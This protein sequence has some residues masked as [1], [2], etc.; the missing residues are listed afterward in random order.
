MKIDN[1]KKQLAKNTLIL[2]IG[3]LS[4]KV[5]SFFLL[6]LYTNVLT[7]EDYGNIDV[8]QTIINLAV[9]I[10]TLQLSGALFR[11]IID[12]KEDIEKGEIVSTSFFISALNILL[13]FMSSLI[14]NKLFQIEPWGLFIFSFI[15]TAIYL[16]MQ[17]LARGFGDNITYSICSFVTVLISLIL[18]IVLILCVGLKGESILISLIISNSVAIIIIC[19]REKIWRYFSIRYFSWKRLGQMLNYSLP[20]IPNAISWWIANASDR[21][22]ISFFLGSSFNGIY[23]AA[24]KIPTIYTTVYNVFNLAWTE[25]VSRIQLDSDKEH[26]INEMLE[27]SYKFFGCICLG[28]ISC[29]SVFFNFL[30]G[31]DYN[32]AYPHVY[33][34]MLAIFVNSLCSMYGGVF[35]G[36][37]K[38]KSIGVTT[39]IGA[40]VNIILNFVFMKKLGLYA[41]SISTLIAYLVIFLLRVYETNKFISIKI[42][43]HFMIRFLL[44]LVIVT[45]G[46][47]YQ[48][49]VLNLFIIFSL[50]VWFYFENKNLL[51]A[52]LFWIKKKLKKD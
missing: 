28:I 18:N 35:T 36:Y 47:F 48:N 40:V 7:T 21:L 6:P 32:S 11:F 51:T 15:T 24:N 45:I 41:A 16:M 49:I 5:F 46:Y 42:P 34:L 33:I 50:I 43:V 1:R 10:V 8:L 52:L 14:G 25:S 38:S 19:V 37:M 29:M 30:I 22:M 23:A 17:N 31:S 2:S 20:L 9:P 3:T 44:A 4:S 13:F 27:N 12:A 39:V 26:F